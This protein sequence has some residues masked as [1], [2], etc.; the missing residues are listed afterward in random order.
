MEPEKKLKLSDEVPPEE[1][2]KVFLGIFLF[3][4]PIIS[5]ILFSGSVLHEALFGGKRLLVYYFL[6]WA[7]WAGFAWRARKGIELAERKA[8]EKTEGKPVKRA[9]WYG[10][11]TLGIVDG[12]TGLVAL[13]LILYVIL[14]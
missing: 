14:T 11:Q 8:Y 10:W 7:V 1:V 9:L 4:A 12:L 3:V 5:T 13:M 2:R 6:L